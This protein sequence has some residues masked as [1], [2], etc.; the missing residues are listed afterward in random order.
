MPSA[1]PPLETLPHQ[2][3]RSNM[4]CQVV[5]EA[6]AS[7]RVKRYYDPESHRF[8]IGKFLPL[9]MVFPLDF[10]FI[11]STLGGDGDP[12]D[13]LILPEAPLPVGSIVKVTILGVLESEQQ[14]PNKRAKR[15]DR[16]IARLNES[17][18]FSRV[19]N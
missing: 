19:R 3:D 15:N 8:R 13:L 12:I 4:T 18:L 2:L 17:R 1:P 9:G 16:I 11:P 10:A 14:K 6:P 5:V 7:S